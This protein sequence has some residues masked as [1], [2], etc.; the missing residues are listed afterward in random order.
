MNPIDEVLKNLAEDRRALERERLRARIQ[1]AFDAVRVAPLAEPPTTKTEPAILCEMIVE[2]PAAPPRRPSRPLV[3]VAA[4]LL[5]RLASTPMLRRRPDKA[6]W[7]ID[8]VPT[9]TPEQLFGDALASLGFA[10]ALPAEQT[11]VQQ[12]S[13]WKR[14]QR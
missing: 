4:P 9:E 11:V 8:T 6:V 2:A 1:E 3:D 12:K 5:A 14:R 10:P 7:D 13:I